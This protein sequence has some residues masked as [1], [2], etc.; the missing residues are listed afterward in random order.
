MGVPA[1]SGRTFVKI[2]DGVIH[3]I[4]LSLLCRD[5][6][7]VLRNDDG[8]SGLFLGVVKYFVKWVRCE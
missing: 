7:N 3:P 2:R 1:I 8:L 5:V 6:G 4:L